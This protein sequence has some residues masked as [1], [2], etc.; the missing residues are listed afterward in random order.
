[1]SGHGTGRHE[2]DFRFR[3]GTIPGDARSFF[4]P[5]LDAESILAERRD[6]LRDDSGRFA[7]LLPEGTG[8]AIEFQ[9]WL[10]SGS[11]LASVTASS[12]GLARISHKS[13]RFLWGTFF[14]GGRKVSALFAIVANV[15]RCEGR[16]GKGS[17]SWRRAVFNACEVS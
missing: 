1:M 4:A 6:W 3:L 2:N 11:E 12:S 9:Q 7:A 5:S 16:C 8:A 17:R 14:R 15:L 10:A 13:T